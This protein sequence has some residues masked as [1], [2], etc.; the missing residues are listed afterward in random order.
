MYC[1]LHPDVEAVGTCT[2]CGRLICRECSIEVH[3]K[4][5]CRECLSAGKV[6]MA[7]ASNVSRP[8]KDRS[9]ALILEILPGM[10]GFLGLGWIYAGDNSKGIMFLIGFLAWH[11]LVVLP[12]ALITAGGGLCITIPIDLIMIGVSTAA[13][14][15]YTVQHPELF[16]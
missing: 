8:A 10:F 1:Y 3:G 16:K 7:S 9:I 6:N 4:M 2:S 14:N 12:V 11:F 5:V 13:L 15:N